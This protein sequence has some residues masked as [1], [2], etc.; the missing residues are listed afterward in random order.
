MYPAKGTAATIQA[1]VTVSMDAFLPNSPDHGAIL[2][3]SGSLAKASTGVK[4]DAGGLLAGVGSHP[5][6]REGEIRR[7]VL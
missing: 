2:S 7:M 5:A 3:K 4:G 6:L 1:I